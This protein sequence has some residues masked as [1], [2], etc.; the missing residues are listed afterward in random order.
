MNE[1]DK[2]I[3]LAYLMGWALPYNVLDEGEIMIVSAPYEEIPREGAWNGR[4]VLCPY[5]RTEEGLAQFAE[6]LLR[7]PETA[8]Y[9]LFELKSDLNQVNFL[10]AVLSLKGVKV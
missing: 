9:L 8:T 2:S 3:N 1:K 4:P 6:I 10:D 5:N 7:F